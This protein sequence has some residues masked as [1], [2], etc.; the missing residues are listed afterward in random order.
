[1][2]KALASGVIKEAKKALR[3]ERP[4][5]GAPSRQN[6]V[7]SYDFVFDAC[8]N[9]QHLKCLTMFDGFTNEIVFIDVA[10]SIRV[11]HAVKVLELV[12]AERGQLQISSEG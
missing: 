8:A 5:I 10:G 1:L 11:K 2:V 3:L 9:G 4:Q 12:A 6:E 7:W